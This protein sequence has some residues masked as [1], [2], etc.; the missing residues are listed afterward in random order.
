[1]ESRTK[2]TTWER[3]LTLILRLD[4]YRS[5]FEFF[6]PDRER[7]YRTYLGSLLSILTVVTLVGF[8]SFEIDKLLTHD[9]YKL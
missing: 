8:A 7:K 1:M 5:S 3:L 9:N 6:L 2:L 4:F